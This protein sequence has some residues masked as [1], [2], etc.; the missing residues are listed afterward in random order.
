MNHNYQDSQLHPGICSVCKRNVID[1]TEDAVCESCG[2]QGLCNDVNNILSCPKCESWYT[3]AE[4][5]DK[6]LHEKAVE[7][8]LAFQQ[9]DANIK[10][11]TDI[12]NAKTVAIHKIKTAIDADPAI[13]NKDFALAQLIESRFLHL[14]DIIF[15]R[16]AEVVEAEN[17]QKAIQIYYNE[18]AKRLRQEERERI[19]LKDV[20]YQPLPVVVKKS[21]EVKIKKYDV[22]GI[23]RVSADTGVGASILQMLCVQHNITPIEAARLY[24]E[25]VSMMKS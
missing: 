7:T 3:T 14:K 21:R 4:A 12:F 9:T 20:Q 24:K 8:R 13:T 25:T 10:I 23:K 6:T 18:L 22:D 5:T 11:S 16:R 19:R 2:I 17:E 15:A 1:H